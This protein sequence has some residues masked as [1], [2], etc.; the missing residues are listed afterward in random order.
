MTN[1]S[2]LLSWPTL[3]VLARLVVPHQ[4]VAQAAVVDG[5][6]VYGATGLSEAV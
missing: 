6:S 3:V 4:N 1:V 5:L 2:V